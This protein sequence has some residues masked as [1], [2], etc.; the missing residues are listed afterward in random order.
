M[1]A[2]IDT[3]VWVLLKPARSPANNTLWMHMPLTFAEILS[4]LSHALN[5]TEGQP[6]A[7]SD[8]V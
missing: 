8:V 3:N 2:V 1:C 4:A 7:R 5:I 6:R